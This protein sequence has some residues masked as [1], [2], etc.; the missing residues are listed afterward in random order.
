M[1]RQKFEELKFIQKLQLYIIVVALV[2]LVFFYEKQI[3]SFIESKT[4][5]KVAQKINTQEI[6]KRNFIKKEKNQVASVIYEK[7]KEFDAQVV[8]LQFLSDSISTN[9]EASYENSMDILGYINT[10]FNIHKIS[11][12]K[13]EKSYALNLV[14]KS[15]YI[16]NTDKNYI[17]YEN[18]PNP[19]NTK[20]KKE[21][22]KQF[23]LNAIVS[24]NV[25]INN[26]W[27]KINDKIKGYEIVQ[28]LPNSV[29]L[30]NNTKEIYLSLLQK[31][32]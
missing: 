30:K 20:Y 28:I 14:F 26:K 21:S 27:Y 1:I 2:F 10:H 3:Y 13:K 22:N 4:T 15:S 17:A 12:S 25:F 5:T 31:S 6:K 8:S 16:F 18:I 29:K 9:I 32:K 19:F 11:L 7:A 23:T 24:N